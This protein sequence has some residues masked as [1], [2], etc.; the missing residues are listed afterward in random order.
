MEWMLWVAF[1][2]AFVVCGVMLA[3]I[4]RPRPAFET[5][6]SWT[7]EPTNMTISEFMETLAKEEQ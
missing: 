1:P 3:G 6:S 5:V 4:S 7:P 2:V